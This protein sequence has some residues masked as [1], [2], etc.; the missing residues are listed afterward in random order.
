LKLPIEDGKGRLYL[1]DGMWTILG[2]DMPA[3]KRVRI[4]GVDGIRFLV[5]AVS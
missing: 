2:D 1:G 3:G 4:T 5:E